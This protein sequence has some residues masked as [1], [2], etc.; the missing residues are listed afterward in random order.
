MR[1]G[2]WQWKHH[3][4]DDDLENESLA[5]GTGY[6]DWKLDHPVQTQWI[7]HEV[8]ICCWD[9]TAFVVLTGEANHHHPLGFRCPSGSH[10]LLDD[11]VWSHYHRWRVR[12]CCK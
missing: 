6:D 7:S 8:D 5:E 10:S 3:L 12:C 9:A 4:E 11:H 1:L 2:L